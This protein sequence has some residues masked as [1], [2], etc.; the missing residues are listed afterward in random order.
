MSRQVNKLLILLLFRTM[1]SL[2]TRKLVVVGVPPFG[3]LPLVRTLRDDIK[4]DTASNRVALSLNSAI[5]RELKKTGRSW[6]KIAY[7]DIHG[8][9]LKAIENPQKYGTSY[10]NVITAYVIVHMP[11]LGMNDVTTYNNYRFYGD[12]EGML[13]NGNIRIRKLVQ[14]FEYMLWSDKIYVL[15]CSSFHWENVQ[16][17]CGYSCGATPQLHL[18]ITTGST[19]YNWQCHPI[20]SRN[21]NKCMKQNTRNK[22]SYNSINGGGDQSFTK[23]SCV[24]IYIYI[25]IVLS[26]NSRQEHRLQDEWL[27]TE[28][29]RIFQ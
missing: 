26:I 22:F 5:Q 29:D 7:L 4:C 25:C 12:F 28:V 3:C 19:C 6:A 11:C 27:E 21:Y 24:Y 9:T 10:Y 2:G 16:G 23:S 8:I 1:N 17:C 14:G 13:W 15:G 20:R 18:L